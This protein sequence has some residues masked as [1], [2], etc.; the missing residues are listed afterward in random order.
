[1]G[2]PRRSSSLEN[3]E[4][5]DCGGSNEE[6]EEKQKHDERKRIGL[7]PCPNYERMAIHSMLILCNERCDVLFNIKSDHFNIHIIHIIIFAY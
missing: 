3:C 7:G 4:A 5:V 6:R 2:K 1:M